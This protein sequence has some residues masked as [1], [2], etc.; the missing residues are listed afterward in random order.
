MSRDLQGGYKGRGEGTAQHSNANTETLVKIKRM[1]KSTEAQGLNTV[2]TIYWPPHLPRTVLLRAL[3][4]MST[5]AG[6]VL[7]RTHLSCFMT[8]PPQS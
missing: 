6:P 3:I 4:Y 1:S 8:T 2:I 7:S 5:P